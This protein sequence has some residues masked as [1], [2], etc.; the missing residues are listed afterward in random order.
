VSDPARSRRELAGAVVA[1]VVGGGLALSAGGQPWVT[2]TA[3][4]PPPL[5]PVT[6]RISGGEV[7]PLVPA[8]GLLLLAAAVALVAVRGAARIAVGLAM[9]VAG[10]VLGWSGV[11]TAAGGV[12]LSVGDLPT[13]GGSSVTLLRTSVSAGWPVAAAVAGLLAALAAVAVLLRARGWPAMG[14]RYERPGAPAGETGPA[15]GASDEERAAAAWRALDRGVDPTTDVTSHP[16]DGPPD[17]A[18][19]SI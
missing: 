16:P 7:A 5:P 2:V 6:D 11:H 12:R 17:R 3:L 4:R 13:L 15:E 14:R 10:G 1:T 18:G 19:G 8:M 9:A